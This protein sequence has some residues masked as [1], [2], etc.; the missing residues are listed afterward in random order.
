[1][2]FA[3]QVEEVLKLVAETGDRCIIVSEGHAP[4]VVM[5]L[6]QYRTLLKAAAGKEKVA[7]LTEAELL[8]KI[9]QDI[10]EWRESRS[11][12]MA[13][14]ELSQFSVDKPMITP[15]QQQDSPLSAS[16]NPSPRRTFDRPILNPVVPDTDSV[17]E[18]KLE[19]LS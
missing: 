10:A 5:D 4:F 2:T 16:K 12:D 15:K 13:E 14:Y 18:Y 3:D 11:E 7:N 19:P 6:T 8:E 9:N 17:D 1:M